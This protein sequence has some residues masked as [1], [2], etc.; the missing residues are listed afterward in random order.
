MSSAPS[1]A[2]ARPLSEPER[3]LAMTPLTAVIRL[4]APTTLVMLVAS[5]SNIL[6]TYFVSRLGP[7]AIAAVALVFPVAILAMTAVGGGIGSG[8]A[9]A[10]ARAIGGRRTSEATMVAEHSL[11]LAIVM[12]VGFAL[13]VWFGADVLFRVMG[14]RGTVL[15]MASVFAHVLF[16][17]SVITFLGGTF[18]SMLRGEG[19]VKQP[20]FWS[21]MSLGLQ[22]ALTPIFMFPLGLGLI[23]APVAVL[24]S[25]SISVTG[26]AF[27]IYRGKAMVRPALWPKHYHMTPVREILRVGIPAALSTI[28][29]NVSIMVLTGV[30]ARF[31]EDDLAAYGLGT[32]LDFLLL[33][34]CY[35][36][37]AAM[38]TLVGLATGA[39]RADK[40]GSYVKQGVTAVVALMAVASVVLYWRPE[41][42][43][44]IFTDDPDIIAVGHDYFRIV[45]P[46]YPFV[47]ISMV[48]SFAFQG[49]GRATVPLV[50]MAMRV[51]VVLA[52]AL[53][54]TQVLG[55]GE[56]SVFMTIAVANTLAAGGMVYLFTGV[57]RRHT[58][59]IARP[60]STPAA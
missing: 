34:F 29:A 2:A 4:A 18:D 35:G 26:R 50:F 55:Y 44:G 52:V 53:V 24:V 41:L 30:L 13:L 31:G 59:L 25:Q 38:L 9:S 33:S 27:F 32:R 16:G 56:R 60:P 3:L 17:G 10:I 1:P 43:L 28:V 45:G 40:V 48:L 54:C 46:S 11:M 14:G 58:R 39:H 5:A 37:G 57:L 12:G 8:V 36:F 6:Q 42:W 49:L 21:I 23:G 20:A 51:V 15:D 47:G 7:Q 19:N 22:I